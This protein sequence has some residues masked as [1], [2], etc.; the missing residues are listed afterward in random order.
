M[1]GLSVNLMLL[2]PNMDP[3]KP[4]KERKEKKEMEKR[5]KIPKDADVDVDVDEDVHESQ[6]MHRK[7]E[8][9]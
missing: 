4:Q 8:K 1:S 6:M 5:G 7:R 9:R 3:T 2:P